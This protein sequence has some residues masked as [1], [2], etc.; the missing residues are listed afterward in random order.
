MN[1]LAKCEPLMFHGWST[2]EK[3]AF[4]QKKPLFKMLP[5]IR[6]MFE[7]VMDIK[8]TRKNPC[9]HWALADEDTMKQIV[10]N[11]NGNSRSFG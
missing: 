3:L 2:L 9:S 8:L 7:A 10:P 1:T 5:K 11:R 6:L 4:E